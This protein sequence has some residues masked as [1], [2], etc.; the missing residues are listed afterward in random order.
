MNR[1]DRMVALPVLRGAALRAVT[2]ARL[3]T[4]LPVLREPGRLAR[5]AS[6]FPACRRITARRYPGRCPQWW[7]LL[8]ASRGE[9]RTR[10]GDRSSRGA[11]PACNGGGCLCDRHGAAA[12]RALVSQDGGRR[13]DRSRWMV[14]GGS[15][16][17]YNHPSKPGRVT[18]AGHPAD[19]LAP[20]TLNGVPRLD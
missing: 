15:H 14:S 13:D 6:W 19:D 3:S 8:P 1:P 9:A 2:L 16:R 12:A 18:I 5:E 11:L 20:G 17:Q 4:G 10:P 7:I